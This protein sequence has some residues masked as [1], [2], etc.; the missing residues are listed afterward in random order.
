MC[1][2]SLGISYAIYSF[3]MDAYSALLI[4]I[5]LSYSLEIWYEKFAEQNRIIKKPTD[6]I[7]S[8]GFREKT[9]I[10]CPC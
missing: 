3:H 10:L 1:W 2:G 5:N 4:N 6:Y 9:A 8:V 7:K